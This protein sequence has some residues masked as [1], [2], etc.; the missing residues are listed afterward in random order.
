MEEGHSK[1]LVDPT[2]IIVRNDH[3][4]LHFGDVGDAKMAQ[5]HLNAYKL[6]N[7]I[8]SAILL[9][10][11]EVDDTMDRELTKIK[12]AALS[13]KD[14]PELPVAEQPEK[15]EIKAIP[16]ANTDATILSSNMKGL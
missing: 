8:I 12:G 4:F 13:D 14:F 9:V 15:K 5:Q 6:K 2:K 7:A 16:E 10:D 11:E 3:A 1:G